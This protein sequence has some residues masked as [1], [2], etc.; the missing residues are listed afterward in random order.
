M[1]QGLNELGIQINLGTTIEYLVRNLQTSLASFWKFTGTLL[2]S[3][4]DGANNL[5]L[6]S[7]SLV[8]ILVLAVL[9]LLIRGWGFTV[10]T[11]AAFL[12]MDAM[13][14]WTAAMNTLGLVLVASLFSVLIGVPVGILLSR[15]TW[16][17]SIVRPVLD[18]MQTL[19]AFVYLVPAVFFWGVGKTVGAVA[20]IIFAM[21]PAIRL[22]EL[23]IRQ[24]PANVLEAGQAFGATRNQI[25][26]KIQ[27]PLALPT[28]MAGVSQ[29]ILLSL[30]MVVIAGLVGVP[31][32]GAEV[33]RAVSRLDI[34]LG[35]ESGLGV[36][37]LAI[38]L[39]R[40]MEGLAVRTAQRTTRRRSA[41]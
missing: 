9:A 28:I 27:L 32:L 21:P 22:T 29:V 2:E 38:F 18:F 26:F 39:D 25:L 1:P 30:S 37:L 7:P 5:L 11:L 3:L 41:A 40:S 17:S 14:R 4:V 6:S 33:V 36:V 20:T 34:A 35:F 24:V 10:F 8:V 13:G 12:L 19:P 23:G 16:L 15:Y 31:G